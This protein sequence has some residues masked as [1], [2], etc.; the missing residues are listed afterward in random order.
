[1]KDL[2]NIKNNGGVKMKDMLGSS[3]KLVN[4]RADSFFLL[5][6]ISRVQALKDVCILGE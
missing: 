3:A 5:M 6:G 4:E 1:M 2:L